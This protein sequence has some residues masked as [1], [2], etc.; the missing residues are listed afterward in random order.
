[1]L[2]KLALYTN[3]SINQ[4]VFIID[5]SKL[6]LFMFYIYDVG[7]LLYTLIII[8]TVCQYIDLCCL[9]SLTNTRNINTKHR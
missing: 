9:F 8:T 3:Q 4:S 2:L 5:L 7:H 6:Q 1:M